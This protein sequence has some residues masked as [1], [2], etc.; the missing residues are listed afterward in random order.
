MA[1]AYPMG[2]MGNGDPMDGE[3]ERKRGTDQD[4]KDMYRMGKSQQMTVGYQ[5]C[6]SRLATTDSASET[7]TNLPFSASA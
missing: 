2:P 6:D 7:S 4:Q 3:Y 5:T 1:D